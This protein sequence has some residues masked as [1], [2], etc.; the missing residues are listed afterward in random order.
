MSE[1]S[2]NAMAR[3]VG[4]REA[5]SDSAIRRLKINGINIE[6]LTFY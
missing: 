5:S 4:F 6:N 3:G 2:R 1:L